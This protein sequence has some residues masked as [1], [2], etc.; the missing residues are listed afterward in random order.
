[1]RK[2]DIGTHLL[3]IL[4]FRMNLKVSKIAYGY[5]SWALSAPVDLAGEVKSVK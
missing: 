4:Y 2:K 5:H 3:H 1:M